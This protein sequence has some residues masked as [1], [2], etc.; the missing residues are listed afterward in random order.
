VPSAFAHAAPALA[1][2]PV[3][4]GGAA[5]KR[6]WALGALCAIA[7]DADVAA[8]ALGIP[9]EHPLGHRGLSHS[10]PFA[11]ALAALVTLA[12]FPRARAGFSRGRAFGYLFLAAASHG[13]LDAFT[14]GG[15]GVAL[16]APL[17]DARFF[18]PLRPIEVS[19]IGVAR[20]F[21]AR[22]AS[23]LA[24][25]ALWVG[26]PSALFAAAAVLVRRSRRA[27]PAR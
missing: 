18:A 3:F 27:E 15:L 8:F 11:A 7:P 24:N 21:S 2:I 5:P 26:L 17:S 25:E 1:L 12:A 16:L 10:L 23:I 9:Y 19:P 14:D 13:V 20:F 4:A 6:L 22:G